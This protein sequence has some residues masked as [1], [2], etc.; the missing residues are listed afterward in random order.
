VGRSGI[1]RS[2]FAP[3]SLRPSGFL[4]WIL[5][6]EIIDQ[7][8]HDGAIETELAGDRCLSVTRPLAAID[9]S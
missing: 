1:H 9:I 7:I 4:G 6:L 3:C 8:G 5:A 2:S